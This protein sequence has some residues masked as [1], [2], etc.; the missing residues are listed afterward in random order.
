MTVAEEKEEL[1][2]Q[3]GD[4]QQRRESSAALMSVLVII[5]RLTGFART[6]A[7][8]YAVGATVLASCYEVANN[9]PTQIYELVTAGMLVT[10]FLPVYTQTISS[11]PTPSRISFS[12]IRLLYCST[13]A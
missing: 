9:L 8:A 6:W 13:W 3:E 4:A 2:Q 1:V 12:A 5:S 11:R 7:Q 10:A